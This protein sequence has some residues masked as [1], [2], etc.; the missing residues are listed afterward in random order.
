MSLVYQHIIT[1]WLNSVIVPMRPG[2]CV[3][4]QNPFSPISHTAL[5]FTAKKHTPYFI[6]AELNASYFRPICIC[7]LLFVSF[8]IEDVLELNRD[9]PEDRSVNV[10]LLQR[11]LGCCSFAIINL[12]LVFLLLTWAIFVLIICLG[13]LIKLIFFLRYIKLQTFFFLMLLFL[14]DMLNNAGEC[15]RLEKRSQI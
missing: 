12:L 1:L 14:F 5:L 8:H 10:L 2:S 7:Y 11:C 9:V 15:F 6:S 4:I 3:M 13:L